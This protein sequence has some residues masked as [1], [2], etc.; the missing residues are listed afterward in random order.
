[1]WC[2]VCDKLMVREDVVRGDEVVGG[3]F[4]CSCGKELD[5]YCDDELELK[6]LRGELDLDG[7]EE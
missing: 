2:P 7:V 3:V 6:C 5:F 4:V 1:M